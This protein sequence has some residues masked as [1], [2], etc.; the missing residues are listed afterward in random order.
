MKLDSGLSAGS[1][2]GSLNLIDRVWLQYRIWLAVDYTVCADDMKVDKLS[3]F[4]GKVEEAEVI[5]L[6]KGCGD[7][8]K[9]SS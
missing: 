1:K 2:Q 4:E 7:D 8:S 9:L 6:W 3:N 5:S